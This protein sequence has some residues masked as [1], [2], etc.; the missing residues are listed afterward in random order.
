MDSPRFDRASAHLAGWTTADRVG[1][2]MDL[3]SGEVSRLGA[4]AD[5]PEFNAS[6]EFLTTLAEDRTASLLRVR[7]GTRISV[8]KLQDSLVLDFAGTRALAVANDENWSLFDLDRSPIVSGSALNLPDSVCFSSTAGH[9]VRPLPLE[10]RKK[11]ENAAVG[12]EVGERRRMLHQDA[13]GRPWNP[14]DWRGIGAFTPEKDGSAEWFEGVRQWLRLRS[15]RLRLAPDY[16][17][18]EANASGAATGDRIRSCL[19]AG[20]PVGEIAVA[21]GSRPAKPAP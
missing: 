20:V 11:P 6:G 12:T 8:G 19:L 16:K 4:L 17:C 18:G 1:L 15:I 9:I 2:L 10:V 5:Y 21:R 14:C 3:K 13:I 7:D